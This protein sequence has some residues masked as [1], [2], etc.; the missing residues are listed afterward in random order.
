MSNDKL[1]NMFKN[2]YGDLEKLERKANATI[3]WFR[4]GETPEDRAVLEA[5]D[6]HASVENQI[7]NVRET[8]KYL[9][10]RLLRLDPKDGKEG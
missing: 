9:E 5:D 3:R 1:D 6:T 2:S 7:R 10:D 8:L 4:H